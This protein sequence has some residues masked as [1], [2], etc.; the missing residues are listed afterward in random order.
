MKP[1]LAPL[2]LVAACS[3]HTRDEQA[4]PTGLVAVDAVSV[5]LGVDVAATSARVWLR[6]QEVSNHPCSSA[7]RVQVDVTGD[8]AM[9]TERAYDCTGEIAPAYQHARTLSS[10]E[11]RALRGAIDES[12]LWAFA[13]AYKSAELVNDGVFARLEV[14]DGPRARAVDYQQV[15]DPRLARVRAIIL[16]R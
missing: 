3:G 7:V 1:G 5:P 8:V 11:M 9:A 13:S 14:R 2:L 12:G 4:Q 15:E 6:Y 16:R 10:S